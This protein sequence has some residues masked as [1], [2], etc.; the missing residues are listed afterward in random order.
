ME[1]SQEQ[2]LKMHIIII[3]FKSDLHKGFLNFEPGITR[4]FK[5]VR[6]LFAA[7]NSHRRERGIRYLLRVRASAT[8]WV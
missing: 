4:I 8:H 1:Q 3:Q 7:T 5:A 6:D 2:T